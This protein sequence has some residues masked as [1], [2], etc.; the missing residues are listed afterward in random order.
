MALFFSRMEQQDRS[1]LARYL[2]HQLQAR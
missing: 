2:S 1:A